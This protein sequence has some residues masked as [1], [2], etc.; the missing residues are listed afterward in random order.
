MAKRKLK[1]QRNGEMKMMR[2]KVRKWQREDNDLMYIKWGSQ[3]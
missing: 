3:E 1:D 2:Q